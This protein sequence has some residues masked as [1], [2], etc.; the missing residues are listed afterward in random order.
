MLPQCVI[1]HR[2]IAIWINGGQDP[3]NLQPFLVCLTLRIGTSRARRV[4]WPGKLPKD[5]V[6]RQIGRR[7]PC[8]PRATSHD[9]NA[10]A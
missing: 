3:R 7:A 4:T 6:R 2:P 5:Q 8:C 9:Q 1:G 10:K